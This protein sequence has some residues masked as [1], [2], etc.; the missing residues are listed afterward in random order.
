MCIQG[1]V[2]GSR[3]GNSPQGPLVFLTELYL[4]GEKRLQ[5]L[6]IECVSGTFHIKILWTSSE[7]V[8]WLIFFQLDPS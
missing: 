7:A 1:G 5:V 6:L 3:I 4:T 2:C 8:Y